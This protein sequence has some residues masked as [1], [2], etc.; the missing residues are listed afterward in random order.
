VPDP[1][2]RDGSGQAL[3]ASHWPLTDNSWSRAGS[4]HQKSLASFALQM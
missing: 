2:R 3:S 4:I 1:A